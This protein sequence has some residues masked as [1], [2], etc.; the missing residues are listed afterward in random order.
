M[1]RTNHYV[2]GQF[3]DKPVEAF[4]GQFNYNVETKE[5]FELTTLASI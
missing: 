1:I 3:T 2:N 4:L 5:L